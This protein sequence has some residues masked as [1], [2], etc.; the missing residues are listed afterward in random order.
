MAAAMKK[1][2]YMAFGVLLCLFWLAACGKSGAA[3]TSGMIEA[4]PGGYY[5]MTEETLDAS[6]D[7]FDCYHFCAA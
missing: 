5:L 6:G 1:A 3:E 4:R 7:P 2:V